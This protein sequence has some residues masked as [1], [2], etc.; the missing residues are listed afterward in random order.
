M[1]EFN[2]KIAPPCGTVIIIGGGPSSAT[3]AEN[4]KEY[5]KTHKCTIF[6]SNYNFLEALG[7]KSDYTYITDPKKLRENVFSINSHLIIPYYLRTTIKVEF[8]AKVIKKLSEKNK[9]VY[10]VGGNTKHHVYECVGGLKINHDGNLPYYS[11]GIS[12][13]G[14]MIVST[15]CRPKKMVIV[16]I[17]D[18]KPDNKYKMTFEGKKVVY[19]KPEKAIKVRNYFSRV[20]IPTIIKMGITIESFKDVELLGFDRKKLGIGKIGQK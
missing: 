8:I 11:L 2:Y 10:F 4:I 1:R 3:N 13:F 7:V 16:G 17:D 18:P 15:M 9:K 20:L 5:I 6:A 14:T 12:G 19:D